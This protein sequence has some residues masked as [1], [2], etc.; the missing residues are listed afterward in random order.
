MRRRAGSIVNRLRTTSA[1]QEGISSTEF[2]RHMGARPEVVNEFERGSG[3]LDLNLVYLTTKGYKD[4]FFTYGARINDDLRELQ[5]IRSFVEEDQL[6]QVLNQ[7]NMTIPKATKLLRLNEL[8]T[9]VEFAERIFISKTAQAD[10][11][12][13]LKVP[14]MNTVN[15]IINACG[16]DPDS[17]PAQQLR[18]LYSDKKPMTLD[19]LRTCRFID[20]KR[21][22]LTLKGETK[23]SYGEI[24]KQLSREEPDTTP[25]ENLI[26]WLKL[27]PDSPLAQI[28]YHKAKHYKNPEVQFREELLPRVLSEQYL[29]Q[30][31]LNDLEQRPLSANDKETLLS[32]RGKPSLAE[33]LSFMIRKKH[34]R[35][36]LNK[37]AY[38]MDMPEGTI[39]DLIYEVYI[40]RKKTTLLVA[41]HL[42]YS[43]YHPITQFLLDR[44][45]QDRA[46][47]SYTTTPSMQNT[48]KRTEAKAA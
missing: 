22:L 44:S 41:M 45:E 27:P 34:K 17:M 24:N 32:I 46:F 39:R 40:P 21:Y 23:G 43:V 38:Y 33:M 12:Q 37:L 14:R 3:E 10:I 26:F 30:D 29:F 15:N 1:G 25:A 28:I 20:L 47:A 7:D 9:E 42:G 35:L 5:R 31:H 6:M 13:G 16:I 2:G 36:T 4:Y 19:E 48:S 8:E 11:E 18:L